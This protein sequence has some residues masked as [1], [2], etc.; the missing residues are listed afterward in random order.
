MQDDVSSG[1]SVFYQPGHFGAID[2]AAVVLNWFY[3]RQQMLEQ[4]LEIAL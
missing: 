1:L 4:Q 3:T 2:F